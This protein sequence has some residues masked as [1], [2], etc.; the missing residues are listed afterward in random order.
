MPTKLVSWNIYR[1]ERSY[2]WET[3]TRSSDYHGSVVAQARQ[4]H[5]DKT[6]RSIYEKRY[7]NLL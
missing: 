6:G 7:A 3:Y 2:H 1:I 4:H 5:G